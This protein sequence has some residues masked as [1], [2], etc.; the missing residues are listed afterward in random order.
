MFVIRVDKRDELSAYL[1]ENGITTLIHYPVPPHKQKCYANN[2]MGKF[3]LTEKICSEIISLPIYPGMPIEHQEEVVLNIK[4]IFFQ[5]NVK[6]NKLIILVFFKK[7]YIMKNSQILITGGCGYI[8]SHTVVELLEANYSLI[9]LDNFSNSNK[10]IIKRI[11][12][13]TKKRIYYY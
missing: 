3:P 13:I 5:K 2:N 10:G 4:K 1:G 7:K 9:I 12:Q 8:G 11:N 6:F